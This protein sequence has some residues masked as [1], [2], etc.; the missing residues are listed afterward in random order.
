MKR[1]E[2]GIGMACFKFLKYETR[3][4]E[5]KIKIEDVF[6]T[7]LGKWKYSSD[8]LAQQIPNELMMAV[9]TRWESAKKTAK[10]LFEQTL[11]KL[12]PNLTKRK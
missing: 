8:E 5:E 2:E 3:N 6:M 4:D 11:K 1:I 9:K 10:D 12:M 7:K